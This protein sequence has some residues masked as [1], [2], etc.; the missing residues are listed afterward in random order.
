MST[1]D[2]PPL[3]G[4]GASDNPANRYERLRV[5]YG[6]DE[7]LSTKTQFFDDS[8]KSILAE[9]DSPDLGFRYSLN[10]YRGCEHGCAYC[11]ARPSHEYLGFS[12]GLDFESKIMV[13][14]R[15]PELLRKTLSAP[16]WQG[17][18]IMMSGNTDC[19]QPAE[20][21]FQLTRA[22]LQVCAEHRQSVGLITKNALIRR[23][24]DVLQP[25]ASVQAVHA[26]ISITTLDDELAGKLEPR[27]SRPHLRLAAL[28]ALRDAG[29][30]C[31]VMIGPVIPGLNDREIPR[32]L[33]A[34]R[35]HGAQ[36]ASWVMVRLAK[37]LDTLFSQWLAQH[38]PERAEKVEHRIRDC[39]DGKMNDSTW[40]VRQRG[41]GL[42]A[43]QIAQLFSAAARKYGL[44]GKLPP[45]DTAAFR[46][47]SITSP[48]LDLFER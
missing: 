32:I 46:R 24:I 43:E 28:R 1:N 30:P 45:L 23:D 2:K 40:G 27:A 34:A 5:V 22:C 44:D 26:F 18:V 10:A 42:Y 14:R 37:P 15:A 41:T 11:Y 9:N 35:D 7:D 21:N 6:E 20:R 19:Y 29:I 12:A 36:T 4:R 33:E 3:R 17:D 47:P 13:K 48:Q 8:T 25:L 31:G 39:R 38:Y 16:K